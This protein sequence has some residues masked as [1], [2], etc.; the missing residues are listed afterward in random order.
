MWSFGLLAFEEENIMDAVSISR[1][2]SAPAG[3]PHGCSNFGVPQIRGFYNSV[4]S[5]ACLFVL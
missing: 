3:S 2:T 4:K 1:R 5:S